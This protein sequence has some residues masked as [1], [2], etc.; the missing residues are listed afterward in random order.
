MSLAQHSS[1]SPGLAI[2]VAVA[3]IIGV[4]LTFAGARLLPLL[5]G[6][7]G[8][9]AG[10]GVGAI[11]G[12][13]LPAGVPVV[14]CAIGG[15]ALG[16]I[17]ASLSSRLAAAAT[18]ATV[19]AASG[20]LA[21][22]S[23]ERRGWVQLEHQAGPGAA[24]ARPDSN[25]PGLDQREAV[26][27]AIAALRTSLGIEGVDRARGSDAW[28]GPDPTGGRAQPSSPGPGAEVSHASHGDLAEPFRRPEFR[29]GMAAALA[30]P[31]AVGDLLIAQWRAASRPLRTLMVAVAAMCAFIGLCVGVVASRWTAAVTTA[32]VGSLL[33]VG[34]IAVGTAAI[35]PAR[36]ASD[37]P[38]ESGP[39]PG[40]KPDEQREAT[41]SLGGAQGA[42]AAWT[43]LWAA[44]AIAGTAVQTLSRPSPK[45]APRA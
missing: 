34:C 25:G 21:V 27:K 30:P 7:V 33:L 6:I 32:L 12:E 11:L 16:A 28:G 8:L 37:R 31:R 4:L 14:A 5:L 38:S 15:G 9:A 26:V 1:F 45:P 36:A 24:A 13:S 10:G 42:T 20:W 43:A 35:M 19:L 18:L 17:L 39:E 40:S 3:A 2:L 41:P 23:A 44:L 29:V 22:A